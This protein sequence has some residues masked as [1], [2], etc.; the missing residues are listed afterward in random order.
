VKVTPD[1]RV[2]V[3]DFGLAEGLAGEAA[4]AT[5]SSDLSQ[6]PTL[7]HTGTAAGLILGTRRVHGAGAGAGQGRRQARRHLGLRRAVCGDALGASAFFVGETVSDVLAAVLT[8]EPDWSALPPRIPPGVR[9]CCAA[10]SS[11]IPGI[12]LRDIGDARLAIEAALGGQAPAADGPAAGSCCLPDADLAG[13][14]LSCSRRGSRSAISSRSGARPASKSVTYERLT[15][16]SGHFANARFAPDGQTVFYSA[17]WDGNPRELFQSRPRAGEL[18]LGLKARQPAV[19]LARRRARRPA[20][21][22]ERHP[23]PRVRDAGDRVRE[24][25][26]AARDRGRRRLRRLVS[27][28][29]KQLAVVRRRAACCGSSTRWARFGY[30]IARRA[31]SGRACLPDGERVAFFEAE[32]DGI[33][34]AVVDRS[35]KAQL[36]LSSGWATGGTWPGA[37]AAARSGSARREAE[38]PLRLRRGSRGP[39]ARALERAGRS[40]S[41]TSH[42]WS[43][44]RGARSPRAIQ[45]TGDERRAGAEAVVARR[46]GGRGR[47][48]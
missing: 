12:G 29:G 45:P 40:R 35:R 17:T 16:R 14:P 48:G 7:A 33:S 5:S 11:G 13:L 26:D 21:E 15:F 39:R 28:D 24:R 38:R 46:H 19:R 10:A 30:Q 34:L 25:R 32:A 41:T 22:A 2:K 9:D 4:G 6:S 8:R 23:V 18:S 42:R 47:V 3:L 31:C 43:R 27:P 20:P 37:R 36:C 44:A 1:G